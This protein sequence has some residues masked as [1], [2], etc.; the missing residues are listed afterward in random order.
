M[1]KINRYVLLFI[2]LIIGALCTACGEKDTD[3]SEYYTE[4]KI[5]LPNDAERITDMEIRED[6]HWYVAGAS[7]EGGVSVWR[8]KD[9]GNSWE[10]IKSMD[11]EFALEPSMQREWFGF[12]LKDGNMLVSVDEYENDSFEDMR[13][14]LFHV[15]ETGAVKELKV[16]L[17][18]GSSIYDMHGVDESKVVVGTILGNTYLVDIAQENVVSQLFADDEFSL[19]SVQKGD[20]YGLP[21]LEY[22]RIERFDHGKNE[23][24]HKGNGFKAQTDESGE[25][26]FGVA[27][28]GEN[29][30][31]YFANR[32]GMWKSD[33]EKCV[34]IVNGDNSI[35]SD[36][37]VFFADQPIIAVDHKVLLPVTTDMETAIYQYQKQSRSEDPVELTAYTL[38][39]DE[40]V[41]EMLKVYQRTHPNVQVELQVGITE[42]G[43]EATDVI[44]TLNTKIL[45]GEGPDLIFLDSMN[46]ERYAEEGLLEDVS[47]IVSEEVINNCFDAASIYCGEKEVF[48][49]PLGFTFMGALGDENWINGLDDFSKWTEALEQDSDYFNPVTVDRIPS[50]CYA[51]YFETGINDGEALKVEAVKGFYENLK[52]VFESYQLSSEESFA[53]YDRFNLQI[54]PLNSFVYVSEGKNEATMDYIASIKDIQHIKAEKNFKVLGSNEKLLYVPRGVI[55]INKN[56][57]KTEEAKSLVSYLISEEGQTQMG[58]SHILPVNR[59]AFQKSLESQSEE[60]VIIEDVTNTLEAFSAEEVERFVVLADQMQYP[61]RT[62]DILME[63]IMSNAE[64][65]LNGKKSLKKSVS[66]AVEQGNLYLSE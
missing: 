13:Q 39:E 26:A 30:E 16:T 43:Q 56:S 15:T 66:D 4:T 18:D 33:G 36:K 20:I 52:K 27:A 25:A 64:D 41:D 28:D 8:S 48:A 10:L 12:F 1:K 24:E 2:S 62:D 50:I 31:F 53:Y 29:T 11:E 46:V 5:V 14:L 63:I 9:E 3:S 37:N 54:N 59:N 22:E 44:K 47:E 65:Y 21:G 35:L 42:Y 60:V 19:V 51:A 34:Q 23:Y 40:Y 57:D 55:A 6:D 61:V 38:I 32:S 45:G 7:R 17:P 49:I 58:K